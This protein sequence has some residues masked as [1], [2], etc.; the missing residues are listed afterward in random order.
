MTNELRAIDL[1]NS[2]VYFVDGTGTPKTLEIK[3]DEGNLTY[4]VK[5]NLEAKKNRGILDYIKEGD[6]ENM[7]VSLECRFAGIKS[8]TGEYVLP[9]EF[10]TKT[11][12][13]SSYVSTGGAN[14]EAYCIDIVVHVVRDCGTLLN[15]IITFPKFTYSSIGGD[16]KAGTLSVQ[17]ICNATAPTSIRTTGT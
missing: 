16:F 8:D 14:C 17:G 7:D 2:T 10:L 5:R 13:A 1:K 12:A 6:Q 3:I 11:G 4:T 15:E 9:Y